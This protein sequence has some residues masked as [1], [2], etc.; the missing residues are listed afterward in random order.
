MGFRPD[1]CMPSK[2]AGR[3][4]NTGLGTAIVEAL[5]KQ[6]EARVDVISDSNGTSVSVTRATFTSRIPRAA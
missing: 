1:D 6:L 5:V 3:A 2:S 4:P